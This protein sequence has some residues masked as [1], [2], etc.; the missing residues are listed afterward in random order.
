MIDPSFGVADE[1]IETIINER[2]DKLEQLLVAD[3][4]TLCGPLIPGID[5]GTRDAI[6]SR[7]QKRAK[8]AVILETG[9]GY[10]DVVDRIVT[11]FRRYYPEAV[12]FYVPNYAMSAGTL[13]AMSGNAIHMDYYSVLGPIDPQV[14]H[15]SSPW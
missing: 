7:Q 15:S 3:V 14:R 9:G 4:L 11:V 13:L 2:V 12:E 1:F 8:L 6:E 5:D 10:S